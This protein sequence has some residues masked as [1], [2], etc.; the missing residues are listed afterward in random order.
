VT[1]R[2]PDEAVNKALIDRLMADGY[3]FL[4]STVLEGRTVLRMCTINPR[5]TEEEIFETI[6]KIEG[7]GIRD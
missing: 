5:T 4:S 6:A 7:L 3:A 2:H 1:F